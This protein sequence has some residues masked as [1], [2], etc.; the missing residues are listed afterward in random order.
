VGVWEAAVIV[1]LLP[2][3]VTA[4]A[5]LSYGLVLHALNVVPYLVGG[6]V[7]LALMRGSIVARDGG[8]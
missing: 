4:E 2:F 5:A 1:A 6:L 7:A 8:P 3:D